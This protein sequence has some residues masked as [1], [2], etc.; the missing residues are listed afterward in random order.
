MKKKYFKFFICCFF[1]CSLSVFAQVQTISATYTSGDIPTAYSAFDAT[2]NGASTALTIT[3]PAATGSWEVVGVD[4]EYDMTA[5]NGAYMSEQMSRIHFQNTGFKETEV[6]GVGTGGTYSYSRTGLTM[7]NGFYAGNTN[8]VFEMEAWRTWGNTTPNDGCGTYYNKVDNNTWKITVYYQ[9]APSCLAPTN[10]QSGNETTTSV[11][12]SW[13]DLNS[14]APASWNIE[15]GA[16]GFTQGTGTSQVVTANPTTITGLTLATDYE[17]YIQS[18]CGTANGNSLWEGPYSFSTTI[19]CSAVNLDVTSTTG[20]TIACQGTA[21]LSAVAS[22][23][24]DDIYWY[25]AAIGGNIVGTGASFTTPV[26]SSTTSYWAS[27]IKMVSGSNGSTPVYCV[28]AYSAG[29]TYGD[30]IDDFDMSSAG[31]YHTGT[32]CSTGNYSDYTTDSSLV[33]V[34]NIGSTYNFSATHN[35]SDQYLKI[36]IDL[37]QD[38]IFSSSELLFTS[39][40]GSSNTVGSITI[41]AANGGA[42]VM[43]VMGGWLAAPADACNPGVSYGETHDY[44]VII[45]D[46]ACESPREEVVATVDLNGD[47]QV[48]TVPYTNINNSSNYGDPFQGTPGTSCGTTENYLNGNDV[49]Y[50]F[51]A[52]NTELVDILLSDLVGFYASV[53]VYDSCGDVGSSCLAGAIAGPSDA[54]FG[55]ENFSVTAGEDYY[56]VVSSWLS[57]TIGYTLDIIPF[58]CTSINVP[59]VVSVQEF[60][61]GDL[62]S[63]LEVIATEPG[64]TFIWYSDAGGTTVIPDTTLLVDGVTYYVSQVFNGCESSLEAV[65][66]DEIDCSTLDIISVTGDIASCRGQLDLTA[67]ASGTGSE[68]YWYDASTGGNIVGIGSNFKTPELTQTTSYWASEVRLVGSGQSS[69]YGMMSPQYGYSSTL[70]NRGVVMNITGA[71]TLVSVDIYSAASTAGSIDIGLFD[72]SGVE[73]A[74]TTFAVPGGG[75][76][77]APV[78]ATVP[79]NFNIPTAGE[80]R[81]LKTSGSVSLMY[82]YNTPSYPYNLGDSELIGGATSVTASAVSYYNYFFYNWTISEDEFVCESIRDEAVAV[83]NQSGDVILDYNDLNY[84]DTNSTAL[85]GNNLSGDAG[86][87][88]DGSGV[89]DGNDVVYQYTADPTNDDIL[90]IELTGVNNSNAGIFIY[91]SCGDIG[92]NCIDGLLISGSSSVTIEDYYISAGEN[93]FI[94]ISSSSGS[95]NYTLNIYG[96][97]C[98]NI[99]LPEIDSVTPYFVSGD[100]LSDID[101]DENI[102]STNLTWYSDAGGTMQIMDPTSEVLVN[103]TTYYVSQTILGCESALLAVSPQEFFCTNLDITNDPSVTICTPGGNVDLM[104]QTSGVGSEIFWY[105]SAASTSPIHV[106]DTYST[107]VSQTTSYWVSEVFSDGN[108]YGGYGLTNWTYGYGSTTTAGL[109]FTANS[110]FTISSVDVYS[111]GSGGTVDV[112]LWDSSENVLDS[113]SY[114]IPAGS[115]SSPTKVVLPVVF[116]VPGPGDYYLMKT[117]SADLMYEY[118]FSNSY[119]QYPMSLGSF[120]QITTSRYTYSTYEYDYYYRFF[121]NWIVTDG[122]VICESSPQEVV[123]TVNDVVPSAPAGSASQTFCEGATIADLVASASSVNSEIIWYSGNTNY[124]MLSANTTLVD[125]SVYYASELLDACESD[126][127][128]SV[129]VKITDQADLPNGSTNQGVVLGS[130]VSDLIVL[131]DNLTWYYD[132][133]GI[134]EIPDPASEVLKDQQTYYVTQSPVAFCE[135]DLLPVTV[136]ITLGNDDPVFE[137]L[138]YYPNPTKA[139]VIIENSTP[140]NNISIYNLLGQKVYSV[141]ANSSTLR[142][143]TSMLATGSYMLEV[144]IGEKV[145]VYKLL[146]E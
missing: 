98:S 96:F 44:K 142:V 83:V 2:C 29:C 65:T 120:G 145:A 110:A 122:E 77:S 4:V 111:T 128:L 1:F 124:S 76:N 14:V 11:D 133:Y 109:K 130:T 52:P 81:L 40:S 46:V 35:Y 140:I 74:S 56:I 104:A 141:N 75:S 108:Y 85:Y 8:L 90:T 101:V 9:D 41:P 73:I 42:T 17:F 116:D 135:S 107:N 99:D 87:S 69:G 28:P 45:S 5:N 127:R 49:V 54:D 59:S 60:V 39:A 20:G 68:I 18:N 113:K 43:R 66:V 137:K 82:E 64:A 126:M 22:G 86:S 13:T 129:T 112:E 102:N 15:Y 48:T 106:G 6:S 118:D 121:Y 139:Y 95:V 57:S 93:V 80:Y 33:G 16:P 119:V 131:G 31:I 88:C 53:F 117:N 94:V 144:I 51:T 92:V 26:I 146:K 3:L 70:T 134:Q 34:M 97:D 115:D 12:I 79:L 21:I 7:A 72:D 123:V 84:S 103:G 143:D 105:D 23:N 25:D 89:L 67:V 136:H 24:G 91:D 114:T 27:E 138:V 32:G 71:T 55:I 100:V 132:Q 62:I 30:D 50:K 37:D 10:V 61:S 36:W 58:S 125:G 63:D 78:A 47:I 19:D 38:G